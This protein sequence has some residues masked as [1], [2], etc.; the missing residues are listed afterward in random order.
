MCSDGMSRGHKSC[1][2]VSVPQVKSVTCHN[3]HHVLDGC[4]VSN[5]LSLA[6]GSLPTVNLVV[7]CLKKNIVQLRRL[8]TVLVSSL[9]A[10]ESLSVTSACE[11]GVVCHIGCGQSQKVDS[12]N[13]C[14]RMHQI[15]S[16][17]SVVQHRRQLRSGACFTLRRA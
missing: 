10:K 3:D 13:K 15:P 16:C 1:A 2:P 11:D 12:P 5:E 6:F 9:V 4:S 7:T 17:L 8:H 14:S